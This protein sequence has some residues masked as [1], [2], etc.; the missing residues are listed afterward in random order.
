MEYLVHR[1]QRQQALG[2]HKVNCGAH[3]ECKEVFMYEN[4]N[5][6]SSDQ[7]NKFLKISQ[8]KKDIK[9]G[10]EVSTRN[11]MYIKLPREVAHLN[12]AIKIVSSLFNCIQP[13]IVDRIS[14]CLNIG[15]TTHSDMKHHLKTYVF[16]NVPNASQED[17]S[18]FLSNR[19]ISMQMYKVMMKL[20]PSKIDE[21]NVLKMID[22]WKQDALADLIYF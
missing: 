10:K 2:S 19:T 21:V 13:R 20:G 3:I 12:H 4:E 15:V 5:I 22:L 7:M 8:L 6:V 17:V 16:E 9:A 18:L 14:Y 1:Q 11:H